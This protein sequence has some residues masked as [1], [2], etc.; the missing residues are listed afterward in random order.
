MSSFSLYKYEMA[1]KVTVANVVKKPATCG[2]FASYAETNGK[3]LKEMSEMILSE[4]MKVDNPV[5][6]AARGYAELL[7]WSVFPLHSIV[8]GECTC[9][10][11][12]SAPGKH[13]RT[14]DGLKSGT[15]DLSIINK[16]FTRHPDSNIGIVTGRVSGFF[17]FDVDGKEGEESLE[18]LISHFGVLPDTV[19]AITG[20]GGSHYLFNYQ[21]GIGSKTNLFPSIDIR[22]DGGYIVVSPSEHV[23]GNLYQWEL[24]SRPIENEVAESPQWL[25]KLLL[26]PK[27]EKMMAKPSS[28]WTSLM[29]GVNEGGRNNAA[30]QLAGH[31]FRRYVHPHLV[32]EIIGLWNEKNNPPIEENELNTIINSIAGKELKR[33]KGGGQWTM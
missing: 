27:Q 10:K 26:K 13:P 5:L 24:S 21:E 18:R 17:A 4:N 12:C 22:G 14:N 1:N 7:L 28:H 25:L 20:S 15:T 31:L 29:N 2:Y 30:A 11:Q 33:R 23:S 16:W 32:V 9:G 6:R 8:N 3:D 19:Q